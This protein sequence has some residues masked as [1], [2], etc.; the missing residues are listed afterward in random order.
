MISNDGEAAPAYPMAAFCGHNIRR[1]YYAAENDLYERLTLICA[2]ALR[3]YPTQSAARRQSTLT[4]RNEQSQCR[5]RP[6][7]ITIS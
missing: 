1:E 5:L 3:S 4:I 2:R 6:R 7:R